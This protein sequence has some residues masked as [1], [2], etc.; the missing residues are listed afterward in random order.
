MF[1]NEENWRT[2]VEIQTRGVY[3][4][5]QKV[6]TN[7]LESYQQLTTLHIERDVHE[8]VE[9]DL[10]NWDGNDIAREIIQ[11]DVLLSQ[12]ENIVERYNEFIHDDDIDDVQLIILVST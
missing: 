4:M 7:D 12:Q 2:V 8:L 3:D 1:T 5:N 11:T 10:I 9:N 6:S